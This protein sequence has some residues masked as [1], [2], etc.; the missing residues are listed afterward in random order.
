MKVNLRAAISLL[1]ALLMTGS[2]MQA[3]AQAPGQIPAGFAYYDYQQEMAEITQPA[4]SSTTETPTLATA[5]CGC[6][7]AGC[8]GGCGACG[9]MLGG[10]SLSGRMGVGLSGGGLT[11]RS[12]RWFFGADY[13]NIRADV[14]DATTFVERDAANAIDTFHQANFDYN[15]S[16]RLYGGYRF[17]DCC[18]ELRLTYTRF[19][20]ESDDSSGEATASRQFNAAFEVNAITPGSSVDVEYDVDADVFDLD[21][22]RTLPLGSPLGH[23]G[24]DWCPAWDIQ[25]FF[26][27]RYADVDWTRDTVTNDPNASTV[28]SRGLMD[29]EGFGPRFGV[30]GRR[31]IGRNGNFS[32]FARGAVSVLL[33]DVDYTITGTTSTPGVTPTQRA[34]F[35]RLIPVTEIELGASVHVTDNFTISGGYLVSAWHDL[36]F[37]DQYFAVLTPVFYG[38]ANILGFDGFF[39]RAEVLY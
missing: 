34:S 24:C 18:G 19:R 9:G 8:V 6:G 17:T 38:D 20:S 16:F 35:T 31:Y 30:D 23:C 11:S 13:L 3:A 14:S 29:F 2:A 21:L 10:S 7:D 12:G 1:A 37:G 26:G 15:S 5:P 4:E 36:G 32:I 25:W 39:V 22:G 33:G 28:S 27:V